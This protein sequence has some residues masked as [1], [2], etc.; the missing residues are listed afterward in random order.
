MRINYSNFQK[1]IQFLLNEATVS[2]FAMSIF[3]KEA[4][5]TG[6]ESLRQCLHRKLFRNFEEGVR[7]SQKV[8]GSG[9]IG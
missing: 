3:Q 2:A 1:Q 8:P 9:T 5:I 7:V 6:V 4:N